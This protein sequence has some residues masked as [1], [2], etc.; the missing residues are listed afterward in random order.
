[1]ALESERLAVDA[2]LE[3]T[4]E[5]GVGILLLLGAIRVVMKGPGRGG[6][7]VKSI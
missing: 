4:A 1:M 7:S 2:T 5:K 6:D 3:G